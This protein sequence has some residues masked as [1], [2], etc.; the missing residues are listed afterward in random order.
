MS[1]QLDAS[2]LHALLDISGV[3]SRLV[4]AEDPELEND[5]SELGEHAY[6][7]LAHQQL[8][9]WQLGSDQRFRLTHQFDR[10][11]DVI[12]VVSSI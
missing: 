1:A 4:K 10:Y 5:T 9:V 2:V 3:D 8:L 6:V 11:Q 7:E 12:D